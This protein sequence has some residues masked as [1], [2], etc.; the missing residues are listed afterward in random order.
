MTAG[1]TAAIS[2]RS[3]G[4]SNKPVPERVG[5]CRPPIGLQ[6]REL[7]WLH[8][9]DMEHDASTF[10]TDPFEPDPDGYNKIF[11]FWVPKADGRGY[12]ELSYTLPQDSTLFLVL[13]ETS[14][15]TRVQKL[16]WVAMR[17][18]M[19]LLN[20]HPDYLRFRDERSSRRTYPAEFYE[21]FL[22]YVRQRYAESL[23]NPLPRELAA[24]V[25]RGGHCRAE[26]AADAQRITEP[27]GTSAPDRTIK[28]RLINGKAGCKNAAHCAANTRRNRRAIYQ[29]KSPE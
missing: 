9:L 10:E 4:P 16:D 12:V 28:H 13:G 22:E 2:C 26:L 15:D 25:R 18:G 11:P 3:K 24:F 19:A 6:L 17:G 5:Y 14:A 8:D 27:A 21:N 7:D 23:W 20:V 29:S 1:C